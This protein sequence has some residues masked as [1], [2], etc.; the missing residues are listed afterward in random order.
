MHSRG[1]MQFGCHQQA[2]FW[3]SAACMS[4]IHASD[5]HVSQIMLIFSPFHLRCA[6]NGVMESFW[7]PLLP[8][9]CWNNIHKVNPLPGLYS[10]N[11]VEDRKLFRKLKRFLNR[12]AWRMPYNPS[13]SPE[14]DP[15]ISGH[16]RPVR[17]D[18]GVRPDH[19]TLWVLDMIQGE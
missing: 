8:L 10:Q 13:T 5:N 4:I 2:Y 1:Q 11:K 15:Q 6:V 7:M 3:T 17:C 16:V 19:G 9:A 18:A 12:D 14:S